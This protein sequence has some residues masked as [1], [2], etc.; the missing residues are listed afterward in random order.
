MSVNST[1]KIQV[2]L[3]PQLSPEVILHRHLKHILKDV[4]TG[5]FLHTSHL[6]LQQSQESKLVPQSAVRKTPAL[7]KSE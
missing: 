6:I 7:S 5:R 3:L 2:I 1:Q 4:L